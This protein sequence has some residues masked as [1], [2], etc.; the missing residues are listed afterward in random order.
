MPS[1]LVPLQGRPTVAGSSEIDSRTIHAQASAH[2]GAVKDI[3]A[4]AQPQGN[5]TPVRKRKHVQSSDA[6]G[7]PEAVQSHVPPPKRAKSGGKSSQM[8]QT[9]EA[10]NNHAAEAALP[11]RAQRLATLSTKDMSSGSS[12]DEPMQDILAA[13]EDAVNT[14]GEDPDEQAGKTGEEDW[15]GESENKP[16]GRDEGALNNLAAEVVNFSPATYAAVPTGCMG[17]PARPSPISTD[18]ASGSVTSLP[19]RP[20]SGSLQAGQG[21]PPL[22]MPVASRLPVAET[23]Q[24]CG[25]GSQGDVCEGVRPGNREKKLAEEMPVIHPLKVILSESASELS[26]D[27]DGTIPWLP[28]TYINTA[29]R[30]LTKNTWGLSLKLCSPEIQRVMREGFERGM[31]YL[32]LGSGIPLNHPTDA[33]GMVTPFGLHGMEQISLGALITAADALGYDSEY[34]IADHLERGNERDYIAPMRSYTAHRLRGYRAEIKK[35]AASAYPA[36]VH[37]TNLS[38]AEIH[39]LLENSNFLY[40]P[41]STDPDK[42]QY[43]QPFGAAGIIDVIR[44]AF[45]GDSHPYKLGAQ[46]I[47][48]FTSSLPSAPHELEIPDAMLAIAATAIHSVLIDHSFK[49]AE[50]TTGGRAS[51]SDFA[52]PTLDSVFKAY[53][54]ILANLRKAAPNTYHALMHNICTVVTGGRA[55]V[56][57]ARTAQNTI[58]SVVD[59]AS[60]TAGQA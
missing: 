38:Q 2:V 1:A 12:D 16:E 8:P 57:E 52:G 9:I 36:A 26:Q 46:N 28:H 20:Y 37:L 49:T 6:A 3:A 54:A 19:A 45:F 50:T 7:D 15:D 22:H 30:A 4:R 42:F 41:S 43:A 10:P 40:P 55:V 34:D 59:W 11:P 29:L 5:K 48:K 21:L 53:M 60:I 27:T 58:L 56:D 35:A 44:A 47:A 14:D 32:A 51:S 13:R 33:A 23:T 17:T 31:A 39:R 18:S 25:T 24:A